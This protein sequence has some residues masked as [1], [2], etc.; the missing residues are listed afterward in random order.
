MSRNLLFFSFIIG[1]CGTHHESAAVTLYVD[2]EVDLSQVVEGETQDATIVG[3]ILNEET[4]TEAEV[5]EEEMP[6]T[7]LPPQVD[8]AIEPAVSNPS[9][10]NPPVAPSLVDLGP[11]QRLAAD[12]EEIIRLKAELRNKKSKSL[13]SPSLKREQRRTTRELN[14]LRMRAGGRKFRE[15]NIINGE[16]EIGTLVV[17]AGGQTTKTS[18]S[19]Y[20][21]GGMVGGKYY[22]LPLHGYMPDAEV[23]IKIVF[24]NSTTGK[25]PVSFDVKGRIQGFFELSGDSGVGAYI[26]PG[27][28]VIGSVNSYDQLA[29]RKKGGTFFKFGIQPEVDGGLVY[30]SVDERTQLL[31]GPALRGLVGPYHQDGG[32]GGNLSFRHRRLTLQFATTY[33]WHRSGESVW[34]KDRPKRLDQEQT[35]DGDSVVRDDS[36]GYDSG[37]SPGS[38]F[39]KQEEGLPVYY[40]PF[41]PRSIELEG[42]LYWRPARFFWIGAEGIFRK[43]MRRGTN[44]V[45]DSRMEAPA[46]SFTLMIKAGVPF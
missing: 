20:T 45:N 5:Q 9:L 33:R 46:H 19:D 21:G 15:G 35:H 10:P 42:K 34:T 13:L 36:D 4:A 37:L 22:F 39:E 32:A 44:P 12:K 24:G 18:D 6:E 7:E 17:Y 28:S 26:R 25:V 43:M 1:M 2:P 11:E 30:T 8:E 40:G 14:L 23:D 31:V 29:F 16:R 41:K 38:L 27:A 3:V